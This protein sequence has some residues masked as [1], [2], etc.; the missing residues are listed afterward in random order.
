VAHDPYRFDGTFNQRVE[1][2]EAIDRDWQPNR[3]VDYLGRGEFGGVETDASPTTNQATLPAASDAESLAVSRIDIVCPLSTQAF[4][5]KVDSTPVLVW[6]PLPGAVRY[7][8]R[9]IRLDNHLFFYGFTPP[10]GSHSYQLGTGFGD[11][12]H[13]NTLTLKSLFYWTVEAPDGNC[14]SSGAR[15]RRISRCA[16]S[17]NRT[18][19]IFA[20]RRRRRPRRSNGGVRTNLSCASFRLHGARQRRYPREPPCHAQRQRCPSAASG[21]AAAGTGTATRRVSRT[22]SP[23][24]ATAGHRDQP[25]RTRDVVARSMNL[26]SPSVLFAL[27]ARQRRF[28]P[29]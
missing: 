19:L 11:V 29:A 6:A 12:L 1:S 13:E 3:Q 23:P 22:C 9:I 4:T 10:D 7:L 24:R 5:A 28:T 27:G 20:P 26:L 2:Y 8:V 15:P 25:P 21:T 17:P 16:P 18:S 14:A